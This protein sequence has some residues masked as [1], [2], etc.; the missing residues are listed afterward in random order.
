MNIKMSQYGLDFVQNTER[1]VVSGYNGEM[2]ECPDMQYVN[3]GYLVLAGHD[4][5]S[6]LVDNVAFQQAQP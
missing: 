1:L 5:E 2:M 6:L 4:S 3:G